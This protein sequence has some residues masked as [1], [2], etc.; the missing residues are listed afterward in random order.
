MK[1][2]YRR[3]LPIVFLFTVLISGFSYTQTTSSAAG[4]NKMEVHF[5]DVGQGD[6]ALITCGGHAMLID[7][8]DDSRGTAIQNYLQKQ[9]IK[10]L[11][12]LVLTHP[13]ADHIGGA[14]VV[15]TKFAS[16]RSVI[17]IIIG[18]VWR[19]NGYFSRSK[20]ILFSCFRRRIRKFFVV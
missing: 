18:I 5:I 10:K 6:A 4:P 14:P 3:I 1:K 15:I 8:G 17:R 19:Q 12:Y 9:N 13:D 16:D 20:S 2:L 11:D 7:A